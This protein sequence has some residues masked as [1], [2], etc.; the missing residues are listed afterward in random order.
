MA[1][2]LLLESFYKCDYMKCINIMYFIV[3]SLHLMEII[4]V[5]LPFLNYCT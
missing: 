3:N 4:Y 5:H 1:V 2:Q